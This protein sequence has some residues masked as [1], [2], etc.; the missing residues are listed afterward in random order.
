[1]YA[2]WVTMDLYSNDEGG[3]LTVTALNRLP[4]EY[5]NRPPEEILQEKKRVRTEIV[6]RE[7]PEIDGDEA[8]K[9]FASVP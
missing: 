7:N 9:E 3:R 8:I 1:M 2:H 6:E 5:E 4:T